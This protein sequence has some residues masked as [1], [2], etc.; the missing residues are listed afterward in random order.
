M[1]FFLFIFFR[2]NN[3]VNVLIEVQNVPILNLC[4]C[5]IFWLHL[6]R[7]RLF[8]INRPVYNIRNR[9]APVSNRN[10]IVSFIEVSVNIVSLG[11]RTDI[12]SYR[13][14]PFDLHTSYRWV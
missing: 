7:K 6:N 1:C 8:K 12:V 2:I 14:E 3:V 13:D 9:Y 10:G 5:Y 11:M 4:S